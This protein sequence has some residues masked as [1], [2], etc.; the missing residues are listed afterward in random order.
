MME[1]VKLGNIKSEHVTL[2]I[3][4]LLSED[5][6]AE[7]PKFCLEKTYEGEYHLKHSHYHVL[8]CIHS[9]TCNCMYYHCQE[10]VYLYSICQL[11]LLQFCGLDK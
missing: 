8:L 2:H 5:E 9:C 11:L 10:I 4:S 7:D 1:C 3:V 6:A